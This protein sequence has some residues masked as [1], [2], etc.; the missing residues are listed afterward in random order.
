M[1]REPEDLLERAAWYRA[2]A[3]ANRLIAD[4]ATLP[5]IRD[6]YE[7]MAR[8]HEIL[9]AEAERAHRLKNGEPPTT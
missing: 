1:P 6:V 5:E 2:K 9:A 3:E 8:A 7:N 4:G